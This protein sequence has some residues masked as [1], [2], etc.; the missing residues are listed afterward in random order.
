VGVKQHQGEVLKLAVHGER[1][2]L[3]GRAAHVDAVLRLTLGDD[4]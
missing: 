3:L 1:L 4:T 2:V